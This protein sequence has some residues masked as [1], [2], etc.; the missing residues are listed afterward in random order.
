MYISY[1]KKFQHLLTFLDTAYGTISCTFPAHRTGDIFVGMSS[2]QVRLNFLHISCTWK[3]GVKNKY[4]M[5]EM[6]AIGEISCAFPA[7]RIDKG[8]FHDFHLT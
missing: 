8:L 1:H 5:Y 3:G 6:H 2:T 7:Y 4:P